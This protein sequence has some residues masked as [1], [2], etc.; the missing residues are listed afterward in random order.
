[1]SCKLYEGQLIGVLCG[2]PKEVSQYDKIALRLR[3]QAL[4]MFEMFSA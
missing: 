3:S 4:F 1:M 2:N